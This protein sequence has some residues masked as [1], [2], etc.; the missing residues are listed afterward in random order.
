MVNLY[1][2]AHW[3]PKTVWLLRENLCVCVCVFWAKNVQNLWIFDR[4]RLFGFCWWRVKFAPLAID[5]Y[6][7]PAASVQAQRCALVL[8]ARLEEELSA[9][10]PD[11]K[12]REVKRDSDQYCVPSGEP[13]TTLNT[14]YLLF[15]FTV[16]RTWKCAP[17]IWD[18]HARQRQWFLGFYHRQGCQLRQRFVL[19]NNLM[20]WCV[21]WGD[22]ETTHCSMICQNVWRIDHRALLARGG[23]GRQFSR[24]Y[25]DPSRFLGVVRRRERIEKGYSRPLLATKYTLCGAWMKHWGYMIRRTLSSRVQNNIYH[26]LAL[27]PEPF[28]VC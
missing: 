11:S 6:V 1:F 14:F 22:V 28:L 9:H 21:E 18:P 8:F 5:R 20:R 15:H 17:N 27:C 4:L 2:G 23:I 7:C 24:P 26:V 25:S 10:D 3:G 16:W 12:W 13:K 19:E